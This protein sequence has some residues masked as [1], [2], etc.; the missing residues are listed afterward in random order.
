MKTTPAV[1]S[2]EPY[3]SSESPTPSMQST[4]IESMTTP[5]VVPTEGTT[6]PPVTF[7]KSYTSSKA[8]IPSIQST[9]VESIPTVVAA[10]DSLSSVIGDAYTTSHTHTIGISTD[11]P[12]TRKNVTLTTTNEVKATAKTST[13]IS[14]TANNGI[15]IP[16]GNTTIRATAGISISKEINNLQSTVK[17]VTYS[18]TEPV[19]VSLGWTSTVQKFTIT[20]FFSSDSN[21]SQKTPST[22]IEQTTYTNVSVS[23]D[24]SSPSTIRRK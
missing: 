6:T 11:I 16:S 9:K 14:Y 22:E 12:I 13:E 3:I 10:I 2:K 5:T 19:S 15:K 18:S 23:F 17:T 24:R 7:P 4:N 1:T 8:P 21:S 20:R